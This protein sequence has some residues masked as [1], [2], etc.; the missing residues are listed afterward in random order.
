LHSNCECKSGLKLASTEST[1]VAE[2]EVLGG[3]EPLCRQIAQDRLP[4][5]FSV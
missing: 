1:A 2:L 4:E 3:V 5:R